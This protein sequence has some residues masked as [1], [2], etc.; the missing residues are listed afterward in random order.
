MFSY[1]PIIHNLATSSPHQLAVLRLD[2]IDPEVS[3]NKWFKLKHNLKK[4][5]EQKHNT[6]I[7]FGGAHSNHIAATAAACKKAGI[8]SVGIIRGDA[9]EEENLTLKKAIENGMT[10][11]YVSRNE[12][13]TKNEADFKQTLTEKFGRHYLVPEGGNNAEGAIGCMEILQ[14]ECVNYDY[15]FCA[16]GT[17]TTFAGLVAT[18]KANQTVVG[19]SVLRGQNNLPLEADTLLKEITKG[20]TKAISGN[21]VLNEPFIERHCITSNYCFS[22]YARLDKELIDF[23]NNFEAGNNVPLDYVYTNKLFYAVSDL[24]KKNKLRENTKLLVI[25]SGGLQ[26]NAAFEKRYHLKPNR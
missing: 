9:G 20:R 14:P 8:K 25:H 13:L 17:G 19:I 26:G 10:L 1:R 2:L 15:I 4:A 21:E 18:V 12:Y 16:C 7:T 3:G 23:K 5:I 6:L 22:G 24:I 11:E